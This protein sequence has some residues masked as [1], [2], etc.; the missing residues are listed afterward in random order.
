MLSGNA[1][2]VPAA[3]TESLRILTAHI[4]LVVATE[5]GSPAYGSV[6]ASGLLLYLISTLVNLAWRRLEPASARLQSD[7]PLA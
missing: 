6:F 2:Q 7:A 1:P 3:P 4:A 5:A